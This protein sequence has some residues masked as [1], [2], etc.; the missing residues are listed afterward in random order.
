MAQIAITNLV[1]GLRNAVVHV[2]IMGD[3]SGDLVDEI[4]VD[5]ATSFELPL[6]AVPALRIDKLWYDLSGFNAF[7]EYDYLSSDTPVWS[8]SSGQGVELCFERFGGLTDYSNELN[9]S[10]KLKLTTSGLILGGFGTIVLGLK[11][12]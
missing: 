10:G 6:P 12:S 4:I 5:P 1:D 9:G 3:G 11:K 7:L 2:S 8:M